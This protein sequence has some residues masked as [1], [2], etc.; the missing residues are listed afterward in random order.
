MLPLP[1]DA[2]YVKRTPAPAVAVVVR[3]YFAAFIKMK[4]KSTCWTEECVFQSWN[5]GCCLK[6][7]CCHINQMRFLVEKLEHNCG[8]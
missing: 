5:R 2:V 3:T 8:L 6:R 4:C 7:V 1:L